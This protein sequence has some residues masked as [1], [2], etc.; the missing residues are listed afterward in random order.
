MVQAGDE[1]ALNAQSSLCTQHSTEKALCAPTHPPPGESFSDPTQSPPSPLPLPLTPME[2]SVGSV[3]S[4]NSPC[5]PQPGPR[6]QE[7]SRKAWQMDP[8]APPFW[9]LHTSHTCAL[10]TDPHRQAQM[11]IWIWGR[12]CRAGWEIW[13]AGGAQE[14]ENTM[15]A[16]FRRV[17]GQRWPQ[18][19]NNLSKTL[20]SPLT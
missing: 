2:L 12:A 7:A 18:D 14:P 5:H 11:L 8:R 1:V 10:C 17:C 20:R 4:W 6:L 9:G 16:S 13:G 3:N 19:N 15:R